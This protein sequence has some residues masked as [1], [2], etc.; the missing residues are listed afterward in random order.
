VWNVGSGKCVLSGGG[1]SSCDYQGCFVDQDVPNRALPVQLGGSS[2]T[3]ESCTQ[4]AKDAGYAYA[5]LQ[6][7]GQCFAGNTLRYALV[8]D[9]ECNTPC[10]ANNSEMCGG[11]YRNSICKV[12]GGGTPATANITADSTNIPYNTSTNLHWL[13]SNATSCTITPPATIGGYPSGSGDVSTGNLINPRTYTISCDPGGANSSVTVNVPPQ[14]NML[15]VVK[16]GQGTITSTL[17]DGGINCGNDCSES[18]ISGTVVRLNETPAS[19]RMFTG[20]SGVTCSESDQ[21]HSTCTFTMGVTGVTVIANFAV[22]PNY[23]EF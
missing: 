7:Y 12:P 14:S 17:P 9:S 1:G 15:T 4:L 3:L 21:K 11:S 19:G 22:D 13:Y 5:G 2:E 8:S 18:Y 6:Y 16:A 23:K 20:W 10:T